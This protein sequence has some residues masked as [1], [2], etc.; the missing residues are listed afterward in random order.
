TRTGTTLGTVAYMSPEQA[1]GEV[2]DARS[3]I[4]SL[5]AVLYEMLTG[6]PPF[7]HEQVQAMFYAILNEEP[8][9]LGEISENVLDELDWIVGK[10]LAKDPDQRYESADELLNDL[11]A[12]R[13]TGKIDS[14]TKLMIKARPLKTQKRFVLPRSILLTAIV[15]AAI[16]LSYFLW[17]RPDPDTTEWTSTMHEGPPR[18]VVN[19][20]ENRT[21]DSSLDPVA[22]LASET[23]AQKLAGMD[24]V[25]SVSLGANSSRS[26]QIDPTTSEK[27]TGDADALSHDSATGVELTV[28]GTYYLDGENLQ[29][30]ARLSLAESGELISA[31]PEIHSSPTAPQDGIEQ[32]SQRVMGALAMY[33]DNPFR[34]PLPTHAPTYEAFVEYR[35]ARDGFDAEWGYAA[36]RKALE[37]LE[38]AVAL[39]STFMRARLFVPAIYLYMNA[40]AGADTALMELDRVQSRMSDY[41]RLFVDMLR[42]G[43]AGNPQATVG[44]AERLERIAPQD[45]LV[46]MYKLGNLYRLN[47]PRCALE[48]YGALNPTEDQERRLV[49]ALQTRIAADCHHALGQYDEE[50]KLRQRLIAYYPNLVLLRMDEAWAYAGT[51]RVEDIRR[52]LKECQAI[53]GQRGFLD[54]NLWTTCDMLL[55]HGYREDAIAIIN[56][57]I[58]QRLARPGDEERPF[59]KGNLARLLYS[60]ERW[61]EAQEL[62]E[63]IL[64]EN[65][66]H[67]SAQLYL[68]LVAARLGDEQMART[69]ATELEEWNEPYLY[70]QQYYLQACFAALLG[71]REH[72]VLLLREAGAQGYGLN[73]DLFH[74]MDLESLHGYPPFEELIRPK[75]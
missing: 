10:T 4:W 72:A 42:V 58:E 27:G 55:A 33:L 31:I 62:W 61:E 20:F 69:V 48:V 21:G 68:G 3:D 19:R 37:H 29:F 66:D 50:L 57:Y 56:D 53:P 22:D 70:G 25:E 47:Q 24:L 9:S 1:R 52:V 13:Q 49:F 46:K 43:I 36:P 75:D 15:A 5:G 45:Q 63:E 60:A 26:S 7:A 2:V 71:D 28:S 23:L 65:P 6:R 30:Q 74:K 51:G 38:R 35:L 14:E 8:L 41:E 64:T 73:H 44:L 59:L 16:V 54:W 40:F 67:S 32:V 18:I 39:D 17:L 12:V 34:Q 11:R